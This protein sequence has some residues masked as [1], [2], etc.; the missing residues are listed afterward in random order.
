M[1]NKFRLVISVVLLLTLVITGLSS[2]TVG[3]NIANVD[4]SR[5]MCCNGIALAG[6]SSQI[7][8]GPDSLSALLAELQEL[9]EQYMLEDAVIKA[10][11]SDS[12]EAVCDIGKH[13]RP[14]I[15]F[16]EHVIMHQGGG[17]HGPVECL[18]IFH[19]YGRCL[20][21]NAHMIEVTWHFFWC[22]MC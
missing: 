4:C 5:S 19:V 11:D 15:D 10:Y 20:A 17:S 18:S 8:R 12:I 9:Q 2:V 16:V 3:G 6:G 13:L 14:V 1:S 7:R 21:C 22:T